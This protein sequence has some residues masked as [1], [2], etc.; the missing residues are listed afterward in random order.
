VTTADGANFSDAKSQAKTGYG[1]VRGDYSA[2]S[3]INDNKAE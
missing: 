1:Y 3:F 2:A